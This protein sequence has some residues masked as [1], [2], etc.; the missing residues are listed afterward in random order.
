MSSTCELAIPN[1]PADF[2]VSGH[3]MSGFQENLVGIGPICDA[4]Y[5]VTFTKDVVS[6]YSPKG[7]MVLMGWRKIEGPRLW[8]MSLLP[9][10]TSTPDITTPNAQQSTLKDFSAYYLP[11][12]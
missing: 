12:V 10:E 3:V 2:P 11:S 4:E 1:L 5:S 8:R 9:Y 6:V 7:H